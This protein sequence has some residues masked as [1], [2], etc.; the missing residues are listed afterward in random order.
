MLR[1]L[2]LENKR[3]ML[4]VCT[5]VLI[6]SPR[7]YIVAVQ[8]WVKPKTVESL[9]FGP[10]RDQNK[11]ICNWRMAV[12][13]V[14]MGRHTKKRKPPKSRTV[15]RYLTIKLYLFKEKWDIF[16][17]KWCFVAIIRFFLQ[18]RPT[19]LVV[20]RNWQMAVKDVYYWSTNNSKSTSKKIKWNRNKNINEDF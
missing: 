19:K 17:S 20:S 1:Y 16:F 6:L 9:Y 2:I 14:K 5:L 11:H 13:G 18:S 15:S 3:T 4:I 10:P 12:P 7:T 8:S